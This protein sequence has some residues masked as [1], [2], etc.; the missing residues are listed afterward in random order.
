MQ[1]KVKLIRKEV[2]AQGTM[3]FHSPSHRDS[4]FVQASLPSSP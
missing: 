3:A 4:S 2:V 1:A